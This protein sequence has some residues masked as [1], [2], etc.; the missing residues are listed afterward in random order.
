MMEQI[1]DWL[2]A[3]LTVSVVIAG[4]KSL[5]P[6]GGVRQVGQLVCGMVLMCVLLRPLCAVEGL[7]VTRFLEDYACEIQ[8][9][10]AE[11]EQQTEYSR[12]AVIEQ[13]C[14][15]YIVEQAAQLGLECRAEVDCVLNEDGLWIPRSARLWGAFDDVTQSRLTQLLE[16]ELGI[17]PAAQTYYL[18]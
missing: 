11:L 4:A 15:T 13:F 9:R 14:G 12:R 6:P 18:T 8:V 7:S 10:E 17:L 1:K 3:V 5:M 2:M 16:T